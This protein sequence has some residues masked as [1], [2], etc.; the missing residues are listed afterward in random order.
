MIRE[1]SAGQGEVDKLSAGQGE[2]D[3]F[4]TEKRAASAFEDDRRETANRKPTWQLQVPNLLL[5]L[6]AWGACS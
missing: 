6:A 1:S 5:L 2:V 4:E 3:K